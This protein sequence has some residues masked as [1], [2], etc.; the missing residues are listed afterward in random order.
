MPGSWC[1][2]GGA[3]DAAVAEEARAPAE[4]NEGTRERGG[5]ES[6]SSDLTDRDDLDFD[7]D[8]DDGHLGAGGGDPSRFD[9]IPMGTVADRFF[10]TTADVQGGGQRGGGSKRKGVL[11]FISQP[12]FKYQFELNL[13]IESCH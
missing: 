6:V 5:G 13:I 10:S 1:L 7:R 2:P 4:G 12:M 11:V 8:G 3:P 9:P